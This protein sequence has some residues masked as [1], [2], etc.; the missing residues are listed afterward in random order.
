MFEEDTYES[1]NN[2]S[3]TNTTATVRYRT[4]SS[5]SSAEER[6]WKIKEY[7][8]LKTALNDTKKYYEDINTRKDEYSRIDGSLH[9]AGVFEGPISD[10]CHENG[11]IKLN[12]YME[13]LMKDVKFIEEWLI[14]YM[15]ACSLLEEATQKAKVDV[16]EKYTSS[17]SVKNVHSQKNAN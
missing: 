7:Q 2:S 9:K 14:S 3:N 6:E 17:L 13:S 8:N 1:S 15:K 11:Y 5:T 12:G 16:I 4:T 10:D